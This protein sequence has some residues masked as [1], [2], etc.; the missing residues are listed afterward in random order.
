M[1]R[2]LEQTRFFGREEALARLDAWWASGAALC[3]LVG[4]G[5]MGKT[6]LARRFARRELAR[7][8]AE[9]V[10]FCDLSEVRGGD[11]LVAALAR[12]LGVPPGA[13][14]PGAEL[15]AVLAARQG[16]LLILDNFEHVVA[17]GRAVVTRWAEAGL[18]ARL[19]VTS[20]EA[21]GLPGE[22]RI[23]LGPLGDDEARD[24]LDDRVRTARAGEPLLPAEQAVARELV[25]RLDGIPLALELCASC[26]EVLSL[27]EIGAR[28]D[29]R[30]H[31]LRDERAAAGAR[32]ATLEVAIAWS[33]ELLAPAEQ[34]GLARCSVFHG[35]FAVDAAEAVLDPGAGAPAALAVVQAL[36]RKSLLHGGAGRG[37]GGRSRLGL[38]ESIRLFA[39]QQLAGDDRDAV[40]DRHAAHYAARAARLDAARGPGAGEALQELAEERDNLGAA[41]AWS[42]GRAPRAAATLALA[43]D[44]LHAARGPAGA[45]AGLL[46]AATAAAERTGDAALAARVLG[47]RGEA[48]VAR[49]ELAAAVTDLEEARRRAAACGARAVEGAALRWLTHVHWRRFDRDACVARGEEALALALALGDPS[50]EAGVRRELGD[51][52]RV[53]DRRAEA[54]EQLTAALALHRALGEPREEAADLT[55]LA[56]F[57]GNSRMLHRARDVLLEVH[58]LHRALDNPADEGTSLRLLALATY[59]L[60]ELP[61]AVAQAEDA[62]TLARQ[63]G[64]RASEVLVL[65]MLAVL[66]LELDREDE[67][68]ASARAGLSLC[69]RHG[70]PRA[71]GDLFVSIACAHL[72]GGRD[73]AAVEAIGEAIARAERTGDREIEGQA[74]GLRAVALAAR[75]AEGEALA[76]LALA[77]AR[78]AGVIDD[79]YRAA[80]DVLEG[81]LDADGGVARVARLEAGGLVEGSAVR[82]ALRI[83]ATR[84][85]RAAAGP[86]GVSPPSPFEIEPDGRWFR[87]PGATRVSL[88]RRPSLAALLAALLRQS[89]AAPGVG[90]PWEALLAAGWPGER[91]QRHAAK[92]RVQVAVRT[93]RR[94]GLEPV[95]RTV[96]EGYLLDPE[97]TRAAR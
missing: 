91:V 83:V 42:A 60:G 70:S 87:A 80:L 97:R 96:D 54:E 44:G 8:E 66:L 18:E 94:D 84:R 16:T 27:P 45:R 88:A 85:G 69:A 35:G 21:L 92:N 68:L 58:A 26:A 22:E 79:A 46:E 10:V 73:D 62:L 76:A 25:R 40:L 77:R 64:D 31:L 5:G 78:L 95:L 38:Y 57:F 29:R 9:R 90:L 89:R 1:S 74:L 86:A 4:P 36:R 52:H 71:E 67:A 59:E 49:G 47:R 37:A 34:R 3:T 28:L 32:H 39:A 75:G 20:R 55:R 11:E 65:R 61:A 56:A 82:G 6:R 17:P 13:A 72:L 7:H 30:F 14:D 41:L 51:A 15:A 43:L 48:A 12:A 50:L 81:V 53:L 33:W 93:L 24:L 23:E 63:C 19:L 2:S